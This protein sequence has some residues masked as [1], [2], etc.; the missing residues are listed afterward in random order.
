MKTKKPR[1]WWMMIDKDNYLYWAPDADK[2]RA[3][4]MNYWR[5]HPGLVETYALKPIL[6]REVLKRRKKK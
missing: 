1:E 4:L 2:S 6:L 3:N 5:L